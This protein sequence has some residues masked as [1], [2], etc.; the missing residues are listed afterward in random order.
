MHAALRVVSI[1]RGFDPREFGLLAFG[2]AGPMHAN[3]LGRLIHAD[4]SRDP[5][6]AGSAQ[7]VRVSRLR[8]TERVRPDVSAGS[9]RTH[10][11]ENLQRGP[12]RTTRRG[13]R[14]GST[15]RECSRRQHRFTFYADCRYFMQDIQMPCALEPDEA[16]DGYA[17]V[18]RERFE[19][20][21]RRRYGFELDA[22]IEIATIRVVGSGAGAGGRAAEQAE[23]ACRSRSRRARGPGL[24]RREVAMRPRSTT[25]TSWRRGS[26]SPAPRWSCNRTPQP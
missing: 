13:G 18:L 22:P 4:P 7:R 3:A 5:G 16:S 21:H 1:E 20:E 2:G 19:D 25:A 9:P 12:D 23:H 26:R 10:R 8:S 14:A 11:R 24:L 15:A 17:A 6:H